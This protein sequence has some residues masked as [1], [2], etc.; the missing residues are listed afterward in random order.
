VDDLQ[1]MVL[2]DSDN[3]GDVE[4]IDEPVGQSWVLDSPAPVAVEAASP[5]SRSHLT[6]VAAFSAIALTVV[7]LAFS[8]GLDPEA[9]I[10]IALGGVVA[11]SGVVLWARSRM[12]RE[13][14]TFRE[15][16][17]SLTGRSVGRPL[18]FVAALGGISALSTS[19]AAFM[20]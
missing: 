18:L 3:A 15:V 4:A 5:V 6:T 7:M 16:I 11:A 14:S 10:A 13:G 8:G 17:E 12:A 20:Q 9:L 19:I 1:A 2:D